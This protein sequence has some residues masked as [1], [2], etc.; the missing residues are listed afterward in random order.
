MKVPECISEALLHKFTVQ[1]NKEQND[2]SYPFHFL[3]D[4]LINKQDQDN[5]MH[6]K[7]PNN[8]SHWF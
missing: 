4:I 3:F 1:L 6:T 7:I 8:Y 5:K 2:F